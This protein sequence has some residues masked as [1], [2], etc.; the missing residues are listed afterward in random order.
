MCRQ[1]ESGIACALMLASDAA[2]VDCTVA[3]AVPGLGMHAVTAA[4]RPASA[5]DSI[6][7]CRLVWNVMG[8]MN[9]PHFRVFIHAAAT[10]QGLAMRFEHPTKSGGEGALLQLC[11]SMP[12]ILGYTASARPTAAKTAPTSCKRWM[13]VRIWPWPCTRSSAS[14]VACLAA[15]LVC[16]TD[17]H[18]C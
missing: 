3:V 13:Q 17:Q 6:C 9:N 12:G 10:P 4:Q 14:D 16:A 18:A 5:A 11:I 15:I 7:L 1:T 2:C 8:M